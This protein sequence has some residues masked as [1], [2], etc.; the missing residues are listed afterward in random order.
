M[1]Q[2]LRGEHKDSVAPMILPSNQAMISTV[3]Q[4]GGSDADRVFYRQVIAHHREGVRMIDKM[5]PY[6]TGMSR[7]MANTSRTKQQ[8]EIAEFE[9]KVDGSS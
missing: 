3:V 2:M 9:K 7:D 6:L 4:A 5:L 8:Q 1:L